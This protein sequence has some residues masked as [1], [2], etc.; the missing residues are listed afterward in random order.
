MGQSQQDVSRQEQPVQALP[1]SQEHVILL[2]QMVQ[3]VQPGVQKPLPIYEGDLLPQIISRETQLTRHQSGNRALQAVLTPQ[4][5]QGQG[6]ILLL[7]TTAGQPDNIQALHRQVLQHIQEA[8]TAIQ[9]LQ[10][11]VTAAV[12]VQQAVLHQAVVTQPA[13]H[14]R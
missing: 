6:Q 2:T 14:H 8:A 12:R 11:A 7:L 9:D 5:I 3:V 4:P 13:G 1:V 10:L